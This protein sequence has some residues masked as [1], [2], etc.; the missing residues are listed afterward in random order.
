MPKRKP[1]GQQ[2]DTINRIGDLAQHSFDLSKQD[3]FVTSLGIQ[4]VHY[5]AMPSPIG[6]KERGDY[7][8][9]DALDTISSNGMLY[10]KAGCFT[11]TMSDNSRSQ[12]RSDGGILDPSTSRIIM[13]RFYDKNEEVAAGDRIYMAP[14]DRVY[15]ADPNADVLVSNYQ[16]M[17]YEADQDNR[18]MFPIVKVEMITDSRNQSY[19][20]GVDFEVTCAGDI[21]WLSGGSSPGI[22]PD[23]KEGRVY[24]VRYLYKAFWYIVSLP[25]EVRMTNVTTGGLRSPERMPYHAVLQREYVYQQQINGGKNQPQEQKTDRTREDP[26]D[27]I[28]PANPQIKVNM[29]LFD[30]NS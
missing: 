13:P 20:E 25:K 10:T 26:Q 30:E 7:R 21:R 17:T 15:I 1:R 3:Q 23:T 2:L 4:F 19:Q 9:S 22:D 12:S 8:R 29:D 18:P 11:A 24:S 16:R 28:D 14:G 5:K 6:L 27:G